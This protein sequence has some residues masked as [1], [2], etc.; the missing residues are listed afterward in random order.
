MIEQATVSEVRGQT[1]VLGC[2]RRGSCKSCGSAFC[3]T[4]TRSF[5]AR[6]T[7]GY[8]LTPGDVVDVYLEPGKTIGA[9]F[10]VLIVPLLLFIAAFLV[11]G[12]IAPAASEGVKALFGLGGLA[13]GFGLSWLYSRSR[14]VEGLPEITKVTSLSDVED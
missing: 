3:K 4:D 7:R 2:K 1:V 11:A 5:E 9:G 12:R 8:D 10:L 13:A 6:N 14:G